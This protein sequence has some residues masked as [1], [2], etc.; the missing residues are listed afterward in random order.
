MHLLHTADF[1]LEMTQRNNF[2]FVH[3]RLPAHDARRIYLSIYL[4]IY[5][6][7]CKYSPARTFFILRTSCLK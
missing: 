5:L 1:L 3:V 7:I 2:S 4:S 6:Y